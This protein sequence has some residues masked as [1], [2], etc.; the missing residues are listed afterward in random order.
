MQKNSVN[1]IEDL[2]CNFNT[3]GENLCHLMIIL[4]R[5]QDRLF[6]DLEQLGNE[7]NFEEQNADTI[8]DHFHELLDYMIASCVWILIELILK[9]RALN[10]EFLVVKNSIDFLL[11]VKSVLKYEELNTITLVIADF[12]KFTFLISISWFSEFYLATA[13]EMITCLSSI[14]LLIENRNTPEKALEMLLGYIEFSERYILEIE[15]DVRDFILWQWFCNICNNLIKLREDLYFFDEDNGL[16]NKK[17][18]LK[19]VILE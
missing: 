12:L 18:I 16:Y 13:T 19:K 8:N 7:L 14:E 5:E 15:D 4:I 2:A 9:L 17:M 11:F 10:T 1:S 3:T 6:R